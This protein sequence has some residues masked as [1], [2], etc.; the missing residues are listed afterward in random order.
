MDH[1]ID[2][3]LNA[4]TSNDLNTSKILL[5]D[6]DVNS[7]SFNINMSLLHI[8]IYNKNY[9]M[10]KLL[11]EKGSHIDNENILKKTEIEAACESGNY[12]IINEIFKY[13]YDKIINY[14]T[15]ELTDENINLKKNIEDLKKVNKKMINEYSIKSKLCED[16]TKINRSLI[17]KISDLEEER[18]NLNT[19]ISNFN[20]IKIDNK[21]K[22]EH[23]KNL[24][25]SNKKLKIEIDNKD[26]IVETLRNNYIKKN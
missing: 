12:N 15:E 10:V 11:L 20:N 24:E 13:K 2:N 4:V 26:Q 21:R 7:Y 23:I 6:V 14:L 17:H 8:A 5:E 18:S 1:K 9:E 3:L 19:I 25:K 16:K 22:R